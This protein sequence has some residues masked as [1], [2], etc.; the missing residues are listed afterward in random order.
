M[1]TPYASIFSK[2]NETSDIITYL[3]IIPVVCLTFVRG[4]VPNSILERGQKAVKEEKRHRRRKKTDDCKEKRNWKN[5]RFTDKMPM[6]LAFKG[7]SIQLLVVPVWV[8]V[9]ESVGKPRQKRREK[10]M[11]L[12]KHTFVYHAQDTN[13][14]TQSRGSE[15][16]S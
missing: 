10:G 12:T 5:N 2:M 7:M 14:S 4:L 11:T 15:I 3:R 1:I 16:I 9:S 6:R 13:I 8:A